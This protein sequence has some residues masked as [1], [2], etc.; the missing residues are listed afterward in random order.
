M[1][2]F[3]LCRNVQFFLLIIIQCGGQNWET[4]LLNLLSLFFKTFLTAYNILFWKW[5]VMFTVVKNIKACSFHSIL[6]FH[7]HIWENTLVWKN[8]FLL[9]GNGQNVSKSQSGFEWRSTDGCVDLIRCLVHSSTTYQMF[10]AAIP[11]KLTCIFHHTL[12]YLFLGRLRL[13]LSLASVFHSSLSLSLSQEVQ[14]GPAKK[15]YMSQCPGHQSGLAEPRLCP[16]RQ[17]CQPGWAHT[18]LSELLWSVAFVAQSSLFITTR[19]YKWDEG[20]KG[21]YLGWGEPAEWGGVASGDKGQSHTIELCSVGLQRPASYFHAALSKSSSSLALNHAHQVHK[22]H[23]SF[24]VRQK[25]K[26][27]KKS[28]Q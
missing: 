18:A 23:L 7:R 9:S 15:V 25:L 20:G 17:R 2:I 6:L 3:Y 11:Q 24:T 8:I 28:H 16:Q 10:G 19:L 12:L 4:W 26:K 13:S 21:G 14:A 5:N 27:K 1:C 22:L